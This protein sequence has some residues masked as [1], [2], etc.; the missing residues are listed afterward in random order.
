MLTNML[1]ICALRCLYQRADL[2]DTGYSD[3]ARPE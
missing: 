1:I 2:S 3:I